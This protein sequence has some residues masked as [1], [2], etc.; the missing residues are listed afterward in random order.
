MA[1]PVTG[2]TLETK[3]AAW[4]PDAAEPAEPAEPE[5]PAEPVEPAEPPST[6]WAS[7]TS[8]RQCQPV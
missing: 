7:G 1:K 2:F 6:R 4:Q 3:S 8:G 5:E